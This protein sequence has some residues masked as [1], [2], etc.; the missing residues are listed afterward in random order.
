VRN[1]VLFSFLSTGQARLQLHR[2]IT[3]QAEIS[4]IFIG[5]GWVFLRTIM[6]IAPYAELQRRWTTINQA[7]IN[8]N[9]FKCFLKTESELHS[10]IFAE[11]LFQVMDAKK[12][13]ECLEKSV[14]SFHT[15]SRGNEAEHVE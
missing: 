14:V 15:V 6:Y 1:V 3:G 10:K 9:V 8:R 5:P 4:H 2:A 7:V 13:N 11:R 12:L